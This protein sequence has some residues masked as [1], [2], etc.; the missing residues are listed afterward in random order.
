MIFYIYFLRLHMNGRMMDTY[1][2]LN[3]REEDFLMPY[4]NELSNTV[5][6]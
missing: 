5:R 6:L 3:G 4:D 1:Q 2:R